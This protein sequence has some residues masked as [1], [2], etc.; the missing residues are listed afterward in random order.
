MKFLLPGNLPAPNIDPG[1][2][3]VFSGQVPEK[4][5]LI[6]SKKINKSTIHCNLNRNMIFI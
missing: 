1:K 3:H 5:R 4:V 2:W 6:T